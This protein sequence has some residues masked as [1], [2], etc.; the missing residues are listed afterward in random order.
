[1]IL[2]WI[3]S[4]LLQGTF[5]P[6]HLAPDLEEIRAMVRVSIGSL[7][8]TGF[9]VFLFDETMPR[10]FLLLTYLI[11]LPALLLVHFGVRKFVHRARA[12]GH[13]RHRVLAVGSPS[14]VA[15]LNGI[16]IA[17]SYAGYEIVGACA[18]EEL[19]V[20]AD[21][22]DVP[23]LGT[24]RDVRR[25]QDRIDADTVMVAGGG[26]RSAADLRRIGWDLEGTDTRLIVAPSVVDIAGQRM[27]MRLVAGLPLVHVEEP[28]VSA[29]GGLIKRI[30]DF[31]V[32]GALLLLLSPVMAA[33]ALVVKLGDRGPVMFKQQRVGLGESSFDIL[34]F[35][36]M[37]V[38]AEK[39]L[40][41]LR[42]LNESKGGV[43]FKLREDPRVT[44]VGRVLRKLSLDELP[45]LWNVVRGDMSLVGPRPPLASEVEK[46]H[47][48]HRRRLLVRPG[49]TGLWQVSGRSGLSFDEAVRLDMYYVDNWSF[50][51][52]LVILFKTVGAV[53][54]R[55]GAH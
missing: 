40:E 47:P 43:L 30:F 36:T 46:Y 20:A 42:H 39:Q 50:V 9:T 38:D 8:F 21:D 49:I 48:D 34:K 15:E 12:Q 4:L 1:M 35:R 55:E 18:P 7:A 32:A 45:Q 41:E 37:V 22:Y 44:R 5:S 31:A 16:L 52:D 11:G 2:I 29:A 54:R 10:A 13:L 24:V 28:Q 33:V 14:A 6:R 26:L 17:N 25:L 53:L 27:Q 19:D 51:G 3:A 23:L